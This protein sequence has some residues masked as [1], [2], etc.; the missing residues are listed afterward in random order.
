MLISI[1]K[2]SVARKPNTLM[3]SKTY[4]VRY[5]ITDY[6]IIRYEYH[7]LSYIVQYAERLRIY[8]ALLLN[9]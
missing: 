1:S 4:H 2:P 3:V 5:G 8:L 7:T 9:S 6:A